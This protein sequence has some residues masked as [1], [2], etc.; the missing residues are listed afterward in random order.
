M[1]KNLR[2][3]VCECGYEFGAKDIRPPLRSATH[4]FYGGRVKRL[5]DTVCPECNKKYTLY[6]KPIRG[7]YEVLDMEVGEDKVK[8]KTKKE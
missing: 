5:S 2:T 7:T 4:G 8:K 3:T 6:L 1:A